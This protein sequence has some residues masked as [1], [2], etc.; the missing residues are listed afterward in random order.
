MSNLRKSSWGIQN[1][2]RES[3]REQDGLLGRGLCWATR[4][5]SELEILLVKS[6][7]MTAKTGSQNLRGGIHWSDEGGNLKGRRRQGGCQVAGRA[8]WGN[9]GQIVGVRTVRG[10][11]FL[12]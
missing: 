9:K 10:I 8:V 6:E 1:R 3:L 4:Q 2:L 7:K 12:S 5:G 11:K